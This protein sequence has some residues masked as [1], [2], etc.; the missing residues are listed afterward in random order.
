MMKFSRWLLIGV[1]L[2]QVATAG[3]TTKNPDK[4]LRVYGPGGPHHVIEECA[5]LFRDR[6]GVDVEVVK[7]LPYNLEQRLREDGDLYYGGAEYML[8]GFDHRNPGVLDM[9]SVV[10][11]HP[12]RIGI[13]VRKGNPLN[14]DGIEDLTKDTIESNLTLY[15]LKMELNK[16][17]AIGDKISNQSLSMDSIINIYRIELSPLINAS[18]NFNRNTI[19]GLLATG[20]INLFDKDLYNSLMTLNVLQ[21]NTIQ[22]V[23]VNLGF[24]MN[25]STRV[26][27]PFNDELSAIGGE[28]LES[29]WK[30][31][32]KV[33]FSRDFIAKLSSKT[34][35]YKSII[36]VREELLKETETVLTNLGE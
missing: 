13:I 31:I 28:P 4:V 16:L 34:L 3:A 33:G 30:N 24:Y 8:E 14:I 35:A 25:Y 7:A 1:L 27:L 32:D 9:N 21:E 19:D 6:Q 36:K 5:V 12:R 17:L 23:N 11:L 29:I 10:K 2:L 18:N 20:N 26:N 15:E 22:T